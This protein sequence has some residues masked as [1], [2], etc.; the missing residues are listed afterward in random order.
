MAD[1]GEKSKLT[2]N[3]GQ[4][5]AIISNEG[6]VELAIPHRKESQGLYPKLS[7]T[8]N[9][10]WSDPF[11]EGPNDLSVSVAGREST[12]FYQ[13][14]CFLNKTDTQGTSC[15]K[16]S[17]RLLAQEACLHEDMILSKDVEGKNPM[18]LATLRQKL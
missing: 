7:K 4:N 6:A 12:G 3:Q 18:C 10:I 1:M 11:V 2:D 5:I 14:I 9:C 16:A 13:H 15:L 8:S 17:S